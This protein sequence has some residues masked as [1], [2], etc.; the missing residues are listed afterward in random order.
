MI[1]VDNHDPRKKQVKVINIGLK[2]F[3]DEIV[4]QDV[5]A[6]QLD[7]RPPVKQSKEVQDLLDMFL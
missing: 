2:P 7:W 5:P 6:L 1:K 4:F 3:Y